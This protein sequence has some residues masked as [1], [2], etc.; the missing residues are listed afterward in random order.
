MGDFV[1]DEVQ[2]IFSSGKIPNY[3]NRTLI[4]LIPKCLN[5]ESLGNYRPI[6][7]CNSID[8]VVSKIIVAQIRPKLPKLVS[9]LETGFVSGRNG[10][11]NAII[12]QELVHSMSKMKGRSG[13]MTIKINLEKA[14][15]HLE[16]SFIRDTLKLFK[17]PI[18]LISLIMSCMSTST[19]SV[20]FTGGV[21]E[22]FCPTRG[23]RQG[24]PLFPYL[25]I[26]C[27]EVLGAMITEK[28]NEKLWN[29]A[30]AS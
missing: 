10:V 17:L 9:P 26:L 24:D 6:S 30:R 22:S 5:P 4:T 28:C 27:M 16:W 13:I 21:L 8:K 15:D 7:L 2:L 14:Y 20:L 18:S 11:D 25:F 1:K 19:I 23:I 3:L 29:P 12:V